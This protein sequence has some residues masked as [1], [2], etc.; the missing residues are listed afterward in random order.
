MGMCHSLWSCAH[1]G[2]YACIPANQMSDVSG[3]TRYV[4]HDVPLPSMTMPNKGLKG[5]RMLEHLA[6][7]EARLTNNQINPAQTINSKLT[8]L[9]EHVCE[10]QQPR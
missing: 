1:A 10:W 4:Q 6:G 8:S 9:A 7:I 5:L 2:T 3:K